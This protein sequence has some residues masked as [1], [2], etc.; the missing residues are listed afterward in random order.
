MV[1]IVNDGNGIGKK[2]VDNELR[3]HMRKSHLQL[4]IK[5][6]TR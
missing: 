5:F 4:Q 1:F 2:D 6:L 3:Q